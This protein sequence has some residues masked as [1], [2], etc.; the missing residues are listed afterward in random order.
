MGRYWFLV[1]VCSCKYSPSSV[2]SDLGGMMRKVVLVLVV[3]AGCLLAVPQAGLAHGH[4]HCNEAGGGPSQVG[5]GTFDP[6]L[7]PGQEPFGHD[8]MSSTTGPSC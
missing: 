5:F 6:I 7:A 2:V 3:V 1:V 8:H 4:M